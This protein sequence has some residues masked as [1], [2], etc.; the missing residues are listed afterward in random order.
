MKNHKFEVRS[1]MFE[2]KSYIN[3]QPS[4][5]K[6]LLPIA[7]L[8]VVTLSGCTSSPLANKLQYMLDPGRPQQVA[9]QQIQRVLEVDR[10]TIEAAFA[11]RSLVYRV[12]ELQYQADYYNEFLVAPAVMVTEHTR[13]WLARSGLFVRVSGPGARGAPTHLLEGNVIELY[14]DLRNKKASAAVM[15]I[16]CFVS[17]FDAQ[18]RPTLAFTRDYAETSPLESRDP[19]GLVDAYSRCFQKILAS[20]QNDLA[21]R[22]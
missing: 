7:L 16:R 6:H 4:N 3:H 17:K 11:S 2:V 22:L 19:A 8:S 15:Q 20:L 13:D 9:E 5:I 21:E 12:D 1:L 14:G 10:F 18:G